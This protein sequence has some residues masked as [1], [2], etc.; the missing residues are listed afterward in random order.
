MT[1]NTLQQYQQNTNPYNQPQLLPNEALYNI[2]S[3]KDTSPQ[4]KSLQQVKKEGGDLGSNIGWGLGGVA[5]LAFSVIALTMLPIAPLFIAVIA[6]PFLVAG[7]GAG[8]AIYGTCLSFLGK[9]AGENVA[10]T[11]E[12]NERVK[13]KASAVDEAANAGTPYGSRDSLNVQSNPLWTAPGTGNH[14]GI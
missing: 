12:N 1:H 3:P 2:Y 11:V 9:N 4:P 8:T 7:T 6:I 5:G 13:Q 14:R 10:V